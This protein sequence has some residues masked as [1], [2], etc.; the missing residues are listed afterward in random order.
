MDYPGKTMEASRVMHEKFNGPIPVGYDVLHT[1][2]NPPCCNPKHLFVGTAFD[3]IQDMQ[4]KGRHRYAEGEL[5]G[6]AV[7]TAVKVTEIRRRVAAG[8]QQNRIAA[9]FGVTPFCIHAVVKRKSWR[10]IP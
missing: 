4:R 2:D 10:H 9:E 5:S 8:E 1:C 3:N 6:H 7:L